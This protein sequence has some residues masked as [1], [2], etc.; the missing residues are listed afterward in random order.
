MEASLL[1]KV[2]DSIESATARSRDNVAR[3]FLDEPSHQRVTAAKL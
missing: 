1:R 2:F 3:M